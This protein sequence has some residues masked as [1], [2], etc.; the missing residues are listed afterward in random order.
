MIDTNA[1][2]ISPLE[3]ITLEATSVDANIV[4]LD[5]PTVSDIQDATIY[6]IAP[7]VFPVG[8][9]AVTWTVVDSSGNSASAIQ[10]IIIVDT[11]K[12]VYQF[13]RIKLS[14]HLAFK[15]H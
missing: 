9:T 14:K 11:T 1:P 12:P 15:R 3:D 5:N 7:D 8:E 13:H 2:E 4:N 6:I 10:T